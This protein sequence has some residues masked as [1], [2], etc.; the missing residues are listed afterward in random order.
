MTKNLFSEE[1]NK[2]LRYA[3]NDMN[4]LLLGQ[5]G[6][7][8]NAREKCC[9]RFRDRPIF[10]FGHKAFREDRKLLDNMCY[11]MLDSTKNMLSVFRELKGGDVFEVNKSYL[12][13][14]SGFY[15][16]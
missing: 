7:R 2:I 16:S 12:N 4:V 11:N 14:C 1:D 8:E 15:I 5:G 13:H 10:K 6:N 3:Q 9:K